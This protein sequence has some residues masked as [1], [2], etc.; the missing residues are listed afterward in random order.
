MCL[1]I[2]GRIETIEENSQLLRAGR[3]RFGGIAREVNLSLVP[4][5]GVGNYVI[6]HAGIAISQIDE[7]E[8][9]KTLALIEEMASEENLE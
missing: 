3:V 4:E 2:P 7:A 5:A 1:A 6:V 8:A 9:Q